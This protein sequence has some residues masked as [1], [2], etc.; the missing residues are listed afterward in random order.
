MGQNLDRFEELEKLLSSLADDELDTAGRTRIGE[1]LDGDPEACEFYLD[2][3][4]LHAHLEEEVGA[5]APMDFLEKLPQVQ[6]E[7]ATTI[8]LATRQPAPP[9]VW[10]QPWALAAAAAVVL[11]IA[12]ISLMLGHEKAKDD[13]T[14]VVNPRDN[15]VAVLTDTVDA[16][17]AGGFQLS[18]GALLPKGTVKLESGLAR[19]QFYSGAHVVLEG[20]VEF[21][22]VDTNTG[23]CN[24]GT[25]RAS[26]PTPAQG[27]TVHSPMV[28]MVDLGTEFAARIKEDGATEIH[29]F[30]GEVEIYD[31]GT[32][33]DLKTRHLLPAGYGV[34]VSA[35]GERVD[36]YADSMAFISEDEVFQR[37]RTNAAANFEKW[38]TFSAGTISTDPRVMAHYPFES[39]S[40]RNRTLSDKAELRGLRDGTIIGGEWVSGRWP[41]KRALEFK[42]PSDRVRININ[43]RSPSLTMMAW[44]K[45]EDL[46][47]R[48]S[49]LLV[50]DG[51]IKNGV[52]WQIT[53][54]GTL[55]F[56]L[57]KNQR[58]TFNYTS[59]AVFG[60]DQLG[61][62]VQVAVVVDQEGSSVHH[63][64]NGEPVGSQR[65]KSGTKP[66]IGEA[67]IGNWNPPRE[68][69]S[70]PVR[71]FHGRIGEFLILNEATGPDEIRKLYKVGLP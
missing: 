56:G 54:G 50:T 24:V 10:K 11:G 55:Q 17:F 14:V 45:V 1:L 13:G 27:F 32:N 26:V 67:Q 40:S 65:F 39:E 16:K 29:V 3:M 69:D 22:L 21:E 43:E 51:T 35:T 7:E 48:F 68:G 33:R 30:Q 4:S 63:Y 12:T 31:T 61:K 57:R 62:W 23:A 5:V 8:Y 42:R 66:V 52:E 59:P 41:G 60:K 34:E 19:L 36:T 37:M 2:Y 18:R 64:F 58:E 38:K 15:A 28:E 25:F 53:R 6:I 70:Y 49:A 46:D 9:P 47:Q 71:N 20:P 44:V